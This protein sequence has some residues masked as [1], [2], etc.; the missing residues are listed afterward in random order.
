MHYTWYNGGQVKKKVKEHT[1]EP[2]QEAQGA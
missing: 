2:Q 1:E